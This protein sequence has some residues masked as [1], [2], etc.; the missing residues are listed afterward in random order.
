MELMHVVNRSSLSYLCRDRSRKEAIAAAKRHLQSRVGI[1]VCL[2]SIALWVK[3]RISH[4]GSKE[5]EYHLPRP[6]FLPYVCVGPCSP[7][8]PSWSNQNK[9][10]GWSM[11]LK[12][13][14]V[15][16]YVFPWSDMS[17]F[18]WHFENREGDSTR[19]LTRYE[20]GPKSPCRFCPAYIGGIMHYALKCLPYIRFAPRY[21]RVTI[22]FENRKRGK[23]VSPIGSDTV[24]Y[25]PVVSC[26]RYSPPT[27]ATVLGRPATTGRI[28]ARD[29]PIHRN[30]CECPMAENPFGCRFSTMSVDYITFGR[31]GGN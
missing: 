17:W 8:V 7:T 22:L 20:Q 30:S 25:P 18:R 10:Q 13:T 31:L 12:R 2:L 5:K 23:C 4:N 19:Y 1:N 15:W 28:E 21:R 26:P 24:L 9:E 16:W 3:S 6:I 29:I 11:T 27:S 14:L